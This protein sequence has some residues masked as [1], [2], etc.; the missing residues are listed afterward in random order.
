MS[1]QAN[2]CNV[3]KTNPLLQGVRTKSDLQAIDV[4]CNFAQNMDY[5]PIPTNDRVHQ[6]PCGCPFGYAYL[7]NAYQFSSG[8][9]FMDLQQ[10]MNYKALQMGGQP[11][12]MFNG[13]AGRPSVGK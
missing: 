6:R 5:G 10:A 1:Q 3:Y 13:Y 4:Y 11:A 7:D 2:I 12:G 8:P 9:D